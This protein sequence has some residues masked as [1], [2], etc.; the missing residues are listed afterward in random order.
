[1][2]KTV[3]VK[4]RELISRVDASRSLDLNGLEYCFTDHFKS[5]S[6]D[7]RYSK[8]P[9]CLKYLLFSQLS[10]QNFYTRCLDGHTRNTRIYEF[11]GEGPQTPIDGQVDFTSNPCLYLL[12]LRYTIQIPDSSWSKT[13]IARQ[14]P[15][16]S[17][18]RSP[19]LFTI[20]YN[21]S[22]FTRP[23]VSSLDG[24][25]RKF[26]RWRYHTSGR[27]QSSKHERRMSPQHRAAVSRM[28][29]LSEG[30]A[31]FFKISFILGTQVGL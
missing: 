6:S 11:L 19:P 28:S 7:F 20:L 21:S 15:S 4:R 3:W 30:Q 29:L 24:G 26:P 18:I 27:P 12:A 9:L 8:K 23:F 13:S 22:R 2:S 5:F 25:H 16:H 17:N 14:S 31:R 10:T 1:M